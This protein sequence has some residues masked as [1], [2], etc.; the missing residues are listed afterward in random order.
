MKYFVHLC[1]LTAMLNANVQVFTSASQRAVFD[2]RQTL[3]Q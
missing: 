2:G 3:G 1:K